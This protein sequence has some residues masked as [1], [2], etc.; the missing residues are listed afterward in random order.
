[1]YGASGTGG[2]LDQ[3]QVLF[4]AGTAV[5]LSDRELLERFLHHG[6]ESGEAAFTALVERHGPMVLRVCNQAL[7][8]PHAAED[9][10]QATF[11]VLA[12]KARSIRQRDSVESW[13]FGVASRAAARIRMMEARRQRYERRGASVR[14]CGDNGVPDSSGPWPELHA[15]IARLAEKYR[16]PIVLCYFEG[17]T[18]DQAAARLGWPLG[19]VKTRLARARDQLR[20][21]LENRGFSSAVLM[22]A[23]YLRPRDVPSVP[24]PLLEL[25][26]RAAARFVSGAGAGEFVSS[27][28]LVISQGVLKA[29]LI[30]KM[31]VAA[32]T[33]FGVAALGMGALVLARQAPGQRQ[34]EDQLGQVSSPAKN[35]TNST[36]ISLNGV[37]DFVPETTVRIH[38]PFDCLIDKVL[39]NIGEHVRKGDPL[40]GLSSIDL[41][42]AKSSYEAAVS[43]WVHD[44]KVLDY[45]TPLAAANNIPH[46]ELIE[47][48]NDEA[49]SRLKMKRAK[50]KLLIYGL[51]EAEIETAKNQD[52][53]QK[54]SMILR[55]S[56]DGV[57]V[58]RNVVLG[59]YYTTQDTLF[60]IAA[61]DAF[62]V[63]ASVDSRDAAKLEV[64]QRVT[65]RVPF[66]DRIIVSKVE[67]INRD[68]EPETGMVSIRTTIGNPDHRLKAGML[69]RLGVDL[70]RKAQATKFAGGS[71][72]EKSH[73]SL[74][75]RLNE[76]ERKL[77]RL[78][79]DTDGRSPNAEIL[80]RLGELERKLDRALSLLPRK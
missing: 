63:R 62:I 77:E 41:A 34:A 17:L 12:R 7:R 79:D 44:K 39:V 75:A 10:F 18:H 6:P 8:D 31:R 70:G 5:G 43:Q 56:A 35:S 27:A 59:N 71:P 46:K 28:V 66:V 54:A 30:N 60:A 36:V 50:D 2:L 72:Q 29:M 67:A 15:E 58:T 26:T 49:Q 55:S 65:L 13:L 1:M 3:I 24:R 76:V 42:V 22:P 48:E 57:V 21:R 52:G 47:V 37:T 9:A 61:R 33:L 80:R 38:A 64:G 32:I 78:L 53:V 68:A 40:L 69:V 11:L 74:E 19:T 23:E 25:T 51:T 20:R 73:L 45:K 14:A 4:T 16:V